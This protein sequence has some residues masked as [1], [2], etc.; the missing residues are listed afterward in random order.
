[1]NA[2]SSR[3][4][5]SVCIP[6]YN[7]ASC[8]EEA[9]RSVLAQS[10][11]DLEV[12][13]FDDGSTDGSWGIL[14]GIRDPRLICRRNTRNLGPQGNW[15]QAIGAARGKYV[16]LFHQ[17]D[18]LAPDC[19]ERQVATLE[20]HPEVVLAFCRREIIRPDGRKLF[21]RG[22]P[23]PDGPVV[24][25]E[26]ARACALRGSNLLG[27]PSALL[28]RN[29]VVRVTGGF[30][31]SIPYLVDLDYWLRLMAHGPAWYDDRALASFRVSRRQWSAR[32]GMGQGAE[33]AA[34]MDRL[35]EGPLRG[36]PLARA[37]GRAMGHVQGLL[38][39]LLYRFI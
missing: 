38:R 8:L 20:E 17:D 25:P 2:P 3:P 33:F 34:F 28:M 11:P 29:T 23:W 18:L 31:A 26:A 27:E 15:N 21:N 6:V 10:F 4:L 30:D 36:Q 14:Q 7:G 12:L 32:I 37:L 13:V 24:A 35:A 5:V 16:K 22:A 39:F 1:M 19:L 9:V